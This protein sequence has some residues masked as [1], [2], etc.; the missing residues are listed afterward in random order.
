[1]LLE[2]QPKQYMQI[3][4]NNYLLDTNIVI[5]IFDGNKKYTDKIYKLNQ[6]N[7]PSIV[8][9]ELFI[10]IN[11]VANKAKHLKKLSQLLE[12]GFITRK[13]TANSNINT[14]K[15]THEGERN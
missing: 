15:L 8:V 14:V 6:F 1:M 13:L 3:T 7:L 5:E 10:G 2:K 11:S 4:G 12:L 9:G